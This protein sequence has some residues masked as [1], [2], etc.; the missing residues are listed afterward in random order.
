M[1]KIFIRF[2]IKGDD[3][4]VYKMSKDI[5]VNADLFEKGAIIK[6][7]FCV[8]TKPQKT[9][10]WVYSAESEKNEN[11]NSLLK[12][13]YKALYP[14]IGAI[15]EY[16]KRYYSLLDIVVYSNSEKPITKYN[17]ALSKDSIR[18]IAKLNTKFSLTIYDW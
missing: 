16:T 4:D 5:A 10:R 6:N 15:N 11:I 17:L 2:F 8:Q 1:D 7:K 9:N 3:L 12:R 14:W 13:M 18:I